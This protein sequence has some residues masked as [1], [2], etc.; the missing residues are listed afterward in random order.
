[1]K[2]LVDATGASKG[3]M[4]SY[5]RGLLGSW[6]K[7]D[8]EDELLILVTDDVSEQ[9]QASLRLIGEVV[10]IGSS[11][12]P[13]RL[14]WQQLRILILI[15]RYRPDVVFS[16]IP[17]APFALRS[18]PLVCVAHDFRH[19]HRPWEFSRLQNVY[20]RVVYPPSLKKADLVIA[21]SERTAEEVVTVTK[22][23]QTQTRVVYMG[24]D[25]PQVREPL[26]PHREYAIAFGHWTNKQ[27]HISIQ[28]WGRLTKMI[29]GFDIQLQVVGVP[30]HMKGSLIELA[31][32]EGVEGLVTICDYL[33]DEEYWPLFRAASLMILPSTF[34]GFGMPVIEAL[35]SRIPVVASQGVGLEE[36]G[37]N[38]VL[39][40]DSASP[41]DFARQCARLLE[42]PL[43]TRDRVDQGEKYA[44][45]FT[46]ERAVLRTRASLIEAVE[47]ANRV[48]GSSSA[49]KD[50]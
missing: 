34:E 38:H 24:A 39:Y 49:R 8:P 5:L 17:V 44:A 10:S 16:I 45:A 22:G 42:S 32:A 48:S 2:I 46:W 4:Q 9:M 33:K 1:M 29:D 28:T 19:L 30:D 7:V 23:V 11:S 35:S 36:A 3:G 43:E 13:N 41:D 40:A 21:N 14:L 37:R 31:R 25:V 50:H 12:L 26:S 18:T 20:R 47:L 15:R 6:P 27:P